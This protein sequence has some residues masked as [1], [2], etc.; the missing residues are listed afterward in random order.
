[1]KLAWAFLVGAIALALFLAGQLASGPRLMSPQA[2]IDYLEKNARRDGV[3]VTDSGLQIETVRAGDGPSPGPDDV[4][5][6]HY[7]GT[8][9]NGHRFDS[10]YARGEPAAFP[11][12][13]VI[14]GWTEALQRMQVGGEYRLAIPSDLAYGPL[15]SGPD[16]P[17]NAVL[18][19]RVELLDMS[20][21]NAMQGMQ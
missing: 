17:P 12:S 5:F 10:S 3:V 8:L 19:F 2:G 4:V 18:L 16:I 13:G 1:M 21:M 20:S 6:V 14:P 11:V 15:G 9:V 7:D